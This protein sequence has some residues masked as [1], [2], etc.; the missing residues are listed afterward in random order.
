MSLERILKRI[1]QN[2]RTPGALRLCDQGRQ[3]QSSVVRV[4]S[5]GHLCKATCRW[6]GGGQQGG[7]RR[8]AIKGFSAGSR[9]RFFERMAR[10]EVAAGKGV[11]CLFVSVTYPADYPSDRVAKRR[12]MRA[13]F[14]R[15]RRRWPKSSGVW[16]LEHQKRG[17]PHFHMI[18]FGLPLLDQATVQSWWR[19][20]IGYEGPY[21]LQ[22]DVQEVKGWRHLLSYVSKY[23]AKVQAEPSEDPAENEHLDYLTY[24]HADNSDGEAAEY[25]GQNRADTLGRVWGVFNGDCLPYGEMTYFEFPSSGFLPTVKRSANGWLR[26]AARSAGKKRVFQVNHGQGSGFTLFC[27]SPGRWLDLCLGAF[28]D[29]KGVMAW[30]S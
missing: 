10:L 26:A 4:V 23:V 5:Q 20:V 16:R 21:T 6:D 22:V 7:G 3:F 11:V 15:I 27:E 12:H 29:G 9:K 18:F 30:S 24:W 2:K 14:E 17:A 13:F 25:L 19:E 28:C 8:G 1:H